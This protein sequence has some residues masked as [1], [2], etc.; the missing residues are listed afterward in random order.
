MTPRSDSNTSAPDDHVSR[1]TSVTRFLVTPRHHSKV[2][3]KNPKSSGMVLTSK[4]NMELMEEKERNKE[5]E[6]KERRK[7]EREDKET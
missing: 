4:E 3:T 6:E 2:P 5:E 7:A 1:A